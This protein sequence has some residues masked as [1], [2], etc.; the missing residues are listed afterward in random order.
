MH[1]MLELPFDLPHIQCK[2]FFL[3]RLRSLQS[4]LNSSYS[5]HDNTRQYK[6]KSA[7][8]PSSCYI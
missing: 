1:H 2:L 8:Q 6:N 4:K 7:N 5:P 3:S